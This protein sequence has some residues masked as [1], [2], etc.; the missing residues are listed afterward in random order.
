MEKVTQQRDL[1]RGR[2][3][4]KH[5]HRRIV[6]SLA[7]LVVFCTTYALILPAITLEKPAY[8]GFKEHKHSDKCYT[9]ELVCEKEEGEG[10]THSDACYTEHQNLICGLEES[11]GHTH[12]EE[13]YQ[14]YDNLICEL[15]ENEEHTHG[16]E[17]YEQ[18]TELVCGLE[19]T[20]G[21]THK[22][23]CYETVR[24]LSCGLEESE[25]HK[26]TKKCY[27]KVLTCKLEEHEHTLACYS[28]P[29]AD[30]ETLAQWEATLPKE[31]ELTGIWADDLLKV[32][33]SQLDYVESS[34]NYKVAK[35]EVTMGYNRYGAW[36][37]CPYEDWCAMFI[38]FC[39]HYAGIPK[40]DMPRAASCTKWV[41]LLTKKDMYMKAEEGRPEP[42]DLV[43]FDVDKYE[44]PDH[45]GIVIEVDE[46]D[47]IKTIEGN[48]GNK[49]AHREYKW[50]DKTLYGYGLLPENP[51]PEVKAQLEEHEPEELDPEEMAELHPEAEKTEVSTEESSAEEQKT[52]EFTGETDTMT[53]RVEAPEGAFPEGTSM[54]VSSIAAEDVMD[55]V[56][57]AVDG[58]VAH[59]DAVDIKF[60]YNGE[61]IEPELP[62]RVFMTPVES[63]QEGTPKVVHVQDDGSAAEVDNV[64]TPEGEEAL[65]F[66]ADSF[67]VYAL[68]YT[69]DFE[70]SV[71]GEVYQLSLP[72]GGF[73]S[74]TDLV[75]ALGIVD[76][77]D[78]NSIAS[79]VNDVETIS[80]S[81]K[82]L[83]WVGKINE[84]TTVGALKDSLN[85]NIQ[86]SIALTEEQIAGINNTPVNA[87][88]WGLISL[89]PFNTDEKLTV[90]M[91]NGNLF[92]I[93]VTDYQEASST[94][95][96]NSTDSFIIAYKDDQNHYHVL[97]T[98]GT[99]EV[100]PS[101]NDID[102]LDNNYK[103]KF[104]YVF[105]EKHENAPNYGEQYYFIRP[106]SDLSQSIAL[107]DV[108][109]DLVQYGT[110][111]IGI[112]PQEGG[113]FYLEGYANNNEDVPNLFFDGTGFKARM[114]ENS[115]I[116]IFKQDDIKKYE[117]TVRTADPEMGLVSGKDKN[118]NA[119]TAVE[120]FVTRTKDSYENNWKIEAVANTEVKEGKNRYLFDYF[121][122][123]GVPVSSDKVEVSNGG[124]TAKIKDGKL[125]IPYNGS[126]VTA[127]FKLNSE[128]VGPATVDDL[129]EWVNEFRTKN[130][131][132]DESATK[133]TAEVYDYE[134][135]IYR[136]DL[137]TKSSLKSFNGIVDLGL[138]LDVSGSMK[139]PSKLIPAP[140]VS[141]E[142]NIWDINNSWQ[143]W[144]LDTNQTY[145]VIAE[146]STRATV[147][148]LTYSSTDNSWHRIDA[149]YT[150]IGDWIGT[151]NGNGRHQYTKFGADA[152]GT[153]YPIYI[154]GDNEADGSAR[155]R[156]YYEKQS[157]DNTAKML[158][159]ILGILNVAADGTKSPNVQAA[160]NTFAYNIRSSQHDFVDLRS[161]D[162]LTIDYATQGGTRT[163][164]AMSDALNFAW[165]NSHTKYAILITDGAPQYSSDK[166]KNPDY[167]GGTLESQTDQLI[168][169][170]ESIKQTYEQRGIKLITVGLSMK[171]VERGSRLLYDIADTIDGERMFFAAESGDEL[172]SILLKI[173]KKIMEDCTVYGDVQ[174]TINDA[175]YI[176]D[177]D[178]G[179]PITA[180]QWITLDGKYT[181]D[182]N[183]PH[184]VVQPDGK[185]IKWENQAFQPEGWLGTVYVKAKEDLLGANAL[186][187]NTGKA[188]FDAK[189][190]ATQS[191]PNNKIPLKEDSSTT[192][193]YT[194]HQECETPRVNVNDL[195]F[196]ENKTEWTVYLGTSVDPKA[197][198]QKLYESIKI[199][200]VVQEGRAEDKD[201]DHLPEI[202]KTDE[203]DNVWYPLTANSIS[204]DRENQGIGN[205]ET[206][207]LKNLIKKLT[208]NDQLDWNKLM[209]G[210]DIVI[211]YHVYGM[212]DNS[213]I[214]ISLSKE[215]V[216]GEKDWSESPHATEVVGTAVEKYT[217]NVLYTPDYS[218]LPKGQGGTSTQD[219]HTGT[220]GTIYQGHAAGTET[221]TNEH[222]IN[223][224][225]RK[226]QIEKVDESGNK[227]TGDGEVAT[228][229]VY[230]KSE[231]G[232]AV[233]GLPAGTYEK[234]AENL[235]TDPS[236]ALTETITFRPIQNNNEELT[237][238][239][240]GKE[241][242]YQKYYVDNTEYYIVEENAP[243]GYTKA[244]QPS[245]VDFTISETKI[246]V[247]SKTV[248]E[249]EE[250]V[251]YNWTQSSGADE[252]VK[253]VKV[254]N[255]KEPDKGTI[256]LK[257]IWQDESG[258]VITENS[259]AHPDSIT[260]DLY[261]VKHV[262][263]W[264]TAHPVVDK[265]PTDTET[266]ISHY[267]CKHNG[268]TATQ[269]IVTASLGC[270]FDDNWYILTAPTCTESGLEARKCLNNP[271]HIETRVVD[272]TGHTWGEWKI[273]VDSTCEDIGYHVQTCTVCGA[274]ERNYDIPAKGHDWGASKEHAATCEEDGY[275]YQEC[276][277]CDAINR[278][279]TIAAL[280]HLWDEGTITKQPTE[281]EEG[282]R[283]YTCTRDASHTKTEPI[284]KIKSTV[285][286]NYHLRSMYWGANTVTVGD[287]W[288]EDGAIEAYIGGKIIV[289]YSESGYD[290]K[291]EMYSYGEYKRLDKTPSVGSDGISLIPNH[292]NNQ[293]IDHG[294]WVETIPIQDYYLE[295]DVVEGNELTLFL[296]ESST[297][298]PTG[299]HMNFTIYSIPPATNGTSSSNK[300]SEKASLSNTIVQSATKLKR[301]LKAA[302]AKAPSNAAS[303]TVIEVDGNN[304]SVVTTGTTGYNPLNEYIN[305][306]GY[307]EGGSEHKYYVVEK[308]LSNATLGA[309]WEATYN[310]DIAD[311]DGNPY[312]YFFV[313]TAPSSG[314]ETS[315]SGQETGLNIGDKTT[316]TNK[317][318]PTTKDYSFTKAWYD[319]NGQI[320]DSW[321]AE[322]SI[323]LYNSKNT[324][325]GD[326][327]LTNEGGSGN[328]YTWT[329]SRNA[330][331]TYTFTVTGLP[332][333]E[334]S[335]ELTYYVTE[336]KVSGYMDPR[337]GFKQG[338]S[339]T[340]KTG[341]ADDDKRAYNG[342]YVINRQEGGFELPSTGGKGT[343]IFYGLGMILLLGA[344][345]LLWKRRKL[346]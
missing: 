232:T 101:L 255:V 9:Q 2:K 162:S 126:V 346:A 330:D 200:E 135:R 302:P 174:D 311:E 106:I 236:N 95:A 308:V 225:E 181:E 147:F 301:T 47:G 38:E 246:P 326:F 203:G 260:F 6:Q 60:I 322:I 91:K 56:T 290:K 10:H 312:K 287:A 207:Y 89:M 175:F 114:Y 310:V 327:T 258:A 337:Y 171:D 341:T 79:F 336:S 177:K 42:G 4:Q 100:I 257:K 227:I 99:Q 74:F 180:G 138:I 210:E 253:I 118:G 269:S 125:E 18:V 7:C 137:T 192:D 133:K 163:D 281:D 127:H 299:G 15:E 170:I 31:E 82:N 187:T 77:E 263:E 283:T 342:E 321:P 28:N 280:G 131:P 196:E 276:S 331:G 247:V 252:T 97:K 62:I 93:Q 165:D 61:E 145:Y 286:I 72:G 324:K 17:C 129:T 216:E 259:D 242:T 139:F 328:G 39:L 265:A 222:I 169:N 45:V 155:T 194:P 11:E 16:P 314:W 57:G 288:E 186:P 316:I 160:W 191:D 295:L 59:V 150:G 119:Q 136:V 88:D 112:L 292:E 132:L 211:P 343:H 277:R 3:A 65:Q 197:E 274:E 345:I 307:T 315:Y 83:L 179:K 334:G 248:E 108:G 58:E 201:G 94:A 230:R 300:L 268:C 148:R 205:R 110:N 264:D 53:V 124:K 235:I 19:E 14:T 98:D 254:T 33:E 282:I 332:A 35:D 26:H 189:S 234:V 122:I 141:G 149:S 313:E 71:N 176:V 279:E 243:K 251:L 304:A 43:F 111:N 21:H 184:G 13:C 223:V 27:E 183:V 167:P 239:Y 238:K 142:K 182:A 261:R 105:E 121:D 80:F 34:H 146:K 309:D 44:G 278:G 25:G 117:F 296:Q 30:V 273:G 298:N 151:W 329:A 134:N 123:N 55:A 159:E 249:Q 204:D 78:E 333:K 323:S 1:K 318:V 63:A 215:V 152:E 244:A 41:R 144:G 67:S 233:E 73:I 305:K 229:S 209:N 306:V 226:L 256:Q 289:S 262:H 128:Y 325:V 340:E 113:G 52:V 266:G 103:W 157:I 87:G 339:I 344:G 267:N 50:D 24:E 68:V 154:S 285:Q 75:K 81:N 245:K 86:Y 64:I 76:G 338:Q 120:S 294:D 96:F 250:V 85:L 178:T 130:I 116:Q 90:V 29:E 297:N 51:N 275:Y 272:A 219:F 5:R 40:A 212:N 158:N 173:I 213:N 102:Y 291:N 172:E 109:E 185:T 37:G 143:Q 46:K 168:S 293:T 240:S 32:A 231:S 36:Y 193:H 115:L 66:E 12:T 195:D 303:G 54:E 161:H 199:R 206:F 166:N 221:S 107:N 284:E 190:Y 188:T 224:I 70:Y 8:C 104:Y 49:V 92:E 335:E 217:L 317:E 23:A 84:D 319:F 69:V 320:M 202:G 48:S 214:K 20:E 164:T 153:T 220:Y 218:V 140:G 241:L 22:E 208:G 270:E 228:F 237:N 198:L 156:S 271:E